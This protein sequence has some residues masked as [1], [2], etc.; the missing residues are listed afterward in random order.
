METVIEIKNLSKIFQLFWEKIMVLENITLSIARDEL[1][2]LYGPSG[3]GK[4]TLINLI[5]GLSEPTTGEVKVVGLDLDLLAKEEIL[6]VRSKY[7]G[8]VFQDKN[9]I[10]TLTV[11]ENLILFQELINEGEHEKKIIDEIL[12]RFDIEERKNS[13]PEQLSAGEKKRVAIARALVNKPYIL[14]LDEPTANLDWETSSKICK[15]IYEIYQQT[16]ITIIIASHDPKFMDIATKIYEVKN[17]KIN[18]KENNPG[19]KKIKKINYRPINA[20]ELYINTLNE[21]NIL[22][23]NILEEEEEKN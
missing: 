21:E 15:K 5:T 1:V 2:L 8:I 17:K 9:L 7:F 20:K 10:S 14:V 11:Y 3:S 6:N 19:R 22:F 13:F 4:T 23:N 18:L 16:D 12:H